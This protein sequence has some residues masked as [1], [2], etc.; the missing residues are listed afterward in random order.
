MNNRIFL[1]VVFVMCLGWGYSSR[2]QKTDFDLDTMGLG[3]IEVDP[4]TGKLYEVTIDVETGKLV[5][6]PMPELQNYLLDKIQQQVDRFNSNLAS[7]F[8]QPKSGSS[9]DRE[10]MLLRKRKVVLPETLEQFIND[11]K[12]KVI[13]EPELRMARR[14]K[15][16]GVWYY[17]DEGNRRN[18]SQN[19]LVQMLVIDFSKNGSMGVVGSRQKGTWYEYKDGMTSTTKEALKKKYPEAV[20][21]MGYVVT[22]QNIIPAAKAQ[23]ASLNRANKKMIKNYTVETYLNNVIQSRSYKNVELDWSG[24][25]FGKFRQVSDSVFECVVQYAMSF[26][27]YSTDMRLIYGDKTY[28]AVTVCIIHRKVG[29]TEEWIAK[30]G[31]ITVEDIKKLY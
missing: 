9:S 2:A 1:L 16:Q 29:P 10:V 27:G 17:M 26:R 21:V 18:I 19:K 5:R 23:V 3:T 15:E 8:E 12:A 13:E 20:E 22:P 11:G 25:K 7:L 31:D 14:D 6:L 24:C 28:K 4:N 30:L